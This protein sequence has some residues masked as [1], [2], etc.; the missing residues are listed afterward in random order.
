MMLVVWV[1]V[2]CVLIATVAGAYSFDRPDPRLRWEDL[3]GDTRYEDN[4]RRY[5][6]WS[7]SSSF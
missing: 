7:D 5:T 2:V 1:T 3:V 6:G 4:D